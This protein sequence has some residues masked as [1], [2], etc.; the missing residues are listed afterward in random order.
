MKLK[1]CVC[2]DVTD[3][4]DIKKWNEKDSFYCPTCV[5]PKVHILTETEL[6]TNFD[7]TIAELN[8]K[9]PVI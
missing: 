9:I 6:K 1:C 4:K 3:W 8:I 7:K 2:G 5:K